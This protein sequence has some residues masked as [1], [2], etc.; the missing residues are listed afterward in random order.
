MCVK[1]F[2]KPHK[3]ICTAV[4]KSLQT[5]IMGMKAMEILGS[6]MISLKSFFQGRM[7]VQSSLM[8]LKNW[9]HKFEIILDFFSNP[10]KIKSIHTLK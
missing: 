8:T 9:M 3:Q 5:L 7:I 2:G 4:F 1:T 10:H 6:L